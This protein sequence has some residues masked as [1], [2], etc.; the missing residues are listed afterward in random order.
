MADFLFGE[1]ILACICG[2]GSQDSRGMEIVEAIHD[3]CAYRFRENSLRGMRCMDLHPLICI[4]VR[5]H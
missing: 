1:T 2:R 3:W 4:S 5:R